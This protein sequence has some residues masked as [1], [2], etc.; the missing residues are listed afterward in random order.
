MNSDLTQNHLLNLIRLGKRCGQL[1]ETRLTPLGITRS[2]ARA[3]VLL[4]ERDALTAKDL[5]ASIPVEP[6]S[7]TR[8]LQDLEQRELIERKPHPTDRRAALLFI[9]DLG[10]AAERQIAQAIEETD[11]ALSSALTPDDRKDLNRLLD[12]LFRQLETLSYGRPCKSHASSLS[13][14]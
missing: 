6:A 9:T 7:M 12:L 1:L 14:S 11:E 3:L 8:L 4:A 5:L 2:Q 13:H 10:R